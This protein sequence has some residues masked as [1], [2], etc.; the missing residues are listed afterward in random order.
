MS[1]EPL[2]DSLRETLEL[3]DGPEAWTPRTTSEVAERLDLGRRATYERLERLVDRDCIETKKVGAR[4]RVWWRPPSTDGGGYDD[5]GRMLSR[6]VDNVPGIVYRRRNEPG[7]SM[8]FVNEAVTDI[9]GYEPDEVTSGEVSWGT[10]IVH[11]D[12]RDTLQEEVDTQLDEE[13]R[14]TVEYRIQAPDGEIR[15]VRERGYAVGEVGDTSTVLEGVITDITEAEQAKRAAIEREQ[16]FRSL[17]EATEKC[18]IFMLDS[19]GHVQTWNRGAT[20]I[21][22]HEFEDIEGEHVSTF[23][24][25][26]ERAAN[27]PEDHLATA[28]AEGVVEDDGWRVRADGSTFWAN[29]TITALYDDHGDLRGYAT[30][31]RDMTD[32]REHEQQ[33]RRERNLIESVLETAP[34]GIGVLTSA[35]ELVRANERA[36]EILAITDDENNPSVAEERQIYD[37]D[38]NPV[39]PAERPYRQAFET[40]EAVLDWQCQIRGSDGERRWL[41]V[42]VAPLEGETGD[43]ERVVTAGEDITQLKEQ[44]RRLERQRDELESELE[45]VFGRI[46]D[47]FYGLDEALRFTYVNDRAESLL[48]VDESDVLG[49]DVHEAITLTDRFAAALQEALEGQEPVFV[50]D[51]YGPLDAWFENALYPSETGLSVYF[52]DVT[53]RKERERELERYET[54][55]ETV[56]DG[57]YVVDQDG[58]FTEVNGAYESMVG[59]TREELVGDHVS[60]VVGEDVLREAQGL[61]DELAANRRATASL[62]A[63]IG[64]EDGDSLTGEATFALMPTDDGYERIGVVRD[65]TERKE[66][67]RE[68]ERQREQ[69]V[70]LDNLNGVV[71]KINEAVI[72]QS[73]REEIE[74]LVV[75]ALANADSYEF[76]WIGDID[77]VTESVELRC[78]AGVEGYLDDVIITVDSDDPRSAGPTG[79]A[80]QTAEIQVC[81]NVRTDPTYEPW[82]DHARELGYRS[83]AAIPIVHEG[84]LYGVLNVYAARPGGFA[85]EEREVIGQ[86]GEIVGHAIAS[87]ERKQ[88][89]M[90]DEVVELEFQVTD[91]FETLDLPVS[92]DGTVTLDRTIP[93][94][95]GSY[96]EYGTATGDA[97]A[98][99]EG[100]V[101]ADS[102]PHW[103]SVNVLWTDGN[104]TRFEIELTEPPVISLVAARGGYVDEARLE[105]GDFSMKIHLAPNTD[106]R[107]VS[108]A[109]Q[110]LYPGLELLT[111]RQK[112]RSGA[113]AMH[114]E[115]TLDEKFT[116]RQRTAIETAYRGGYFEWPRES[117]GEEVADS[118]GVSSS[119]FHQH[120][121]KAQNKL[122]TTVFDEQS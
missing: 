2:T 8:S 46:S 65:V 54:I 122:L 20:R 38:G 117:S 12:D 68:L 109:I 91:I 66:R 101:D 72:E 108:E 31:V 88:A 94:G 114:L 19:D 52:R 71:R 43:I 60:K 35:G 93:I 36:T 118:I 97:M 15:R 3:F 1:T 86:L 121:R 96:L 63:E 92:A 78:E 110:E 85:T 59:F 98:T 105:D 7:W 16:Q 79:R 84:S 51:Y 23:Y 120:L 74:Q 33:L 113:L 103:E 62:E 104:E 10:D 9:T 55:V 24:T 107:H 116:D 47:G 112:Q 106:V 82:H 14:F 40:G 81:Q 28:A 73:T 44:A 115:R 32:R 13:G 39:P 102:F 89:L 11:P 34:V 100:V 64:T 42:N 77:P 6:L 111:R 48:G 5:S 41:S 21:K 45:D 49:Q 17:V 61:E 30:V 69:L 99:V 87:V 83:S 4:G 56:D 29:V 50:E 37:L 27:V 25:G 58:C 95:D 119:T 80:L 57:I 26:E 22:G 76:A 90:S 53:E 70:A 75:D 67:E 18:A